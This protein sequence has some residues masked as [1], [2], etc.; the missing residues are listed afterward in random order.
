MGDLTVMMLSVV[1]LA[2]FHL[3]CSRSTPDVAPVPD[4]GQF[5]VQLNRPVKTDDKQIYCARLPSSNMVR[6]IV[7]SSAW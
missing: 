6:H 3:V 7:I 5:R 1:L 4:R 2:L